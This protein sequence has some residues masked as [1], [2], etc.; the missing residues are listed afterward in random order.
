LRL[1]EP[2]HDLEAGGEK[3]SSRDVDHGETPCR[4]AVGLVDAVSA[5]WTRDREKDVVDG[6]EAGEKMGAVGEGLHAL[7]RREPEGNGDSVS[8]VLEA[9]LDREG[10]ESKMGGESLEVPSNA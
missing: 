2:I 5:N 10:R 1:D 9:M 8:F 4:G 3:D 7:S 6:R